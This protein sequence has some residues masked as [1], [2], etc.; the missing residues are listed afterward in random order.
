MQTLGGEL[1]CLRD[2]VGNALGDPGETFPPVMRVPGHNPS[3]EAKCL[4]VLN[5]DRS[6]PSSAN[7]FNAVL[8]SIPPMRVKSTPAQR[9]ERAAH[10]EARSML[11]AALVLIGFEP[12]GC[13]PLHLREHG[14]D[15]G[16]GFGYQLLM[17]IEQLERLRQAEQ[18]LFAPITQQALGDLLLARVHAIVAKLA[19]LRASRSPATIARTISWP[20][21]P[22]ISLS[23]CTSCTFI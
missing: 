14:L 8:T 17:G 2:T 12:R 21:L 10:I 5:L 15:L 3:Q 18:M 20:V 1:E 7:T 11:G 9:N 19:S 16:V 6:T 4:A 13:M 23:T 22:A